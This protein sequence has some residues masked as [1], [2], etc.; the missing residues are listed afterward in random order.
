MK[1]KERENLSQSDL[2]RTQPKIPENQEPQSITAFYTM[3]GKHIHLS[4]SGYPLINEDSIWLCASQKGK[5]FYIKHDQDGQLFDPKTFNPNQKMI[6]NGLP[7][8]RMVAVSKEQFDL[9]VEFL[10]TSKIS[11]LTQARKVMKHV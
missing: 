3:M 11:F 4:E 8:Y 10:K 1:Q 7:V 6:Q 9:Y 2:F 5:K